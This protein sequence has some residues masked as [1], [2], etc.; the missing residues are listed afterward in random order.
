MKINEIVLASYNHNKVHEFALC[1]DKSFDRH[2]K[3]LSLA[4]VG[5]SDVIEETNPTFEQNALYKAK[6]VCLATGKAAMADD[7]G[8][9]VDFLNGEPGVYSA[10][11]AG[12]HSTDRQNIEKLL[13]KLDGVPT[14]LRTARFVSVIC[15]YFPDGGIIYSRGESRGIIT[16]QIIGPETF[17]Y[18]PV[19]FFPPYNKTF[20]QL[21]ISEKNQISHR[22]KALESF[23]EKLKPHIEK[24]IH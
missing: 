2:I 22:G 3:L 7:S 10:R 1:F 24:P 4:D 17:G 13:T 6:T 23:V 11:Y 21:S 19:F 9:Q 12:E 20:A 16:T 18:D 14:P 15:A 5:F 8:L